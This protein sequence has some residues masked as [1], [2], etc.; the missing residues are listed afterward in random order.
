[1][2]SLSNDDSITVLRGSVVTF[3]CI[4]S[5]I[6]L[7]VRWIYYSP[8]GSITRIVSTVQDDSDMISKRQTEAPPSFTTEIDPPGLF[9]QLTVYD[10]PLMATGIFSCEIVPPCRDDIIIA[11]NTSLTVNPG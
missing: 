10:V 7:P 9:H 6:N 1:M 5:D 8:D 2:L 4:P 11:Q 3:E